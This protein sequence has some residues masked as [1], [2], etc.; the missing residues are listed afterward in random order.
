MEWS[1]STTE[2]N[3]NKGNSLQTE[4]NLNKL[5]V[6][7]KFCPCEGLLTPAACLH[8]CTKQILRS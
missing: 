8:A 7:E 4:G 2:V 5:P 6:D 1:H 3:T